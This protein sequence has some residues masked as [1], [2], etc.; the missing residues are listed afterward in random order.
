MHRA[1]ASPITPCRPLRSARLAILREA[2]LHICDGEWDQAD[3]ALARDVELAQRDAACINLRGIIAQA[4]GQ[5]RLA[6]RCYA[7]ARHAQRN[8]LPAEQNLRRIYELDAFGSSKLP[9]ALVDRLT[10]TAIRNLPASDGPSASPEAL[11]H[12]DAL[13]SI[14]PIASPAAT[15]LGVKRSLDWRGFAWAAA[16]VALVTAIGWPLVHAGPHLVNT[17]VLMLYFVGV[18]WIATHYSRGAAVLASLLS[19]ATFDFVF[20]EPYYTFAVADERYL[21]TFAVML[22]TALVISTLTDR[23]R[24]QSE[25]ARQAWERVETEFLRNTLL[26]G[27][28][29]DLRTPLAAITGASSTLIAADGALD[30]ATRDDLLRTIS[31]ESERMERLVTGLLEMT[32]LESGGLLLKREWQPLQEVIGS[33]LNHVDRRLR[34]RDVAIHL[35]P[36]LPMVHIDAVAIEQVLIN[37]LENAAEYTPAGT[38]IEITARAADAGMIVELADHGPGL[39]PGTEQ[40]VFEKF[41]RMHTAESRHGIGLGLAIARGIVEAHGG[42]ITAANRGGG[43]GGA[44]GTVFRFT[45]PI[46][47]MPPILDTSA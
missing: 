30:A 32:R 11:N 7:K 21:V 31:L 40:R 36:D 46:P 43:G 25:L 3:R 24:T 47:V 45:I 29:H 41:F 23:M 17:N 26:S 34:G 8:Y 42:T 6:R 20:V 35:P 33:A 12:L 10:L 14:S 28:S 37:L 16:T 38:P 44:G 1:A 4:R 22:L 27:V 2:L 13:K 15:M 19:V 9:I 5:W 39:P 18:I